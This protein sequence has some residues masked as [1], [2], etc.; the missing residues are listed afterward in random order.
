M[1]WSFA[2]YLI[3]IFGGLAYMLVV[4]LVHG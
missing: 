4:G 2:L 1:R 3:L